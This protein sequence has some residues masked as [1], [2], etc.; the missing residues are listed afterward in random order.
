MSIGILRWFLSIGVF[1]QRNLRRGRN[2]STNEYNE[3]IRVWMST[4]SVPSPL[5]PFYLLL[6]QIV[7]VSIVNSLVLFDSVHRDGLVHSLI[8]NN[9]IAIH[10]RDSFHNVMNRMVNALAQWV[11]SIFI[12]IQYNHLLFRKIIISLVVV[13]S[14]VVVL[15]LLFLLLALLLVNANVLET[16]RERSESINERNP[17]L[18]SHY[19]NVID[20]SDVIVVF[21]TSKSSMWRVESVHQSKDRAPLRSKME[22]DGRQRGKTRSRGDYCII[23]CRMRQRRIIIIDHSQSRMSVSSNWSGHS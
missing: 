1:P 19:N 17:I 5:L 4:E 9:A 6:S 18:P 2:M 14:P 8:V 7:G 12:T 13:V 15:L 23:P 11:H 22:S 21:L 20:N 10:R 3:R 16:L